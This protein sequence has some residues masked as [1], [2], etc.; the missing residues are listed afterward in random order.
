M[1]RYYASLIGPLCGVFFPLPL[2][3]APNLEIAKMVGGIMLNTSRL[4]SQ[5]HTTYDRA[6]VER[7]ITEFGNH[8]TMLPDAYASQLDYNSHEVQK[9]CQ[10]L[11]IEPSEIVE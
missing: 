11:A 3:G 7:Q 2:D 9:M 10:Q 5:W 4:K 8:C 6:E 1:K